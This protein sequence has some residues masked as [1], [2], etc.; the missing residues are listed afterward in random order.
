M[1]RRHLNLSILTFSILLL[2]SCEKKTISFPDTG[3]K[4]ILGRWEWV[5]SY[6]GWSGPS[7][8]DSTGSTYF[9]TFRPNGMYTRTEADGAEFSQSYTVGLSRQTGYYYI[10][11][12]EG[13]AQHARIANDSLYL[14][15]DCMDCVDYIFVRAR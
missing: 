9:I 13:W 14:F 6:G 8:P 5:Y 1:F 15:A 12:E 7:N 10:S 2:A 3:A 4:Q 11:Y